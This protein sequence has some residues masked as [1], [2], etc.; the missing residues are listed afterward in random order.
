MP[1]VEDGMH[2][3]TVCDSDRKSSVPKNANHVEDVSMANDK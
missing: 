1:H 2:G 3:G